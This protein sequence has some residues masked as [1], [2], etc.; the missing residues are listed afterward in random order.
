MSCTSRLKMHSFIRPPSRS[1]QSIFFTAVL[2]NPFP[3][4]SHKKIRQCQR[5]ESV[6]E[7]LSCA[8]IASNS[9]LRTSRPS[10][11]DPIWDGET[12]SRAV[13]ASVVKAAFNLRFMTLL[14]R[15]ELQILPRKVSDVD[16][17]AK[18]RQFS[19]ICRLI[20]AHL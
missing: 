16:E 19:S 8:F 6:F 17:N 3:Y 5:R 10:F 18:H 13:I 11:L 2:F 1:N 7:S 14:N 15:N 9:C 12:R 4:N 20:W